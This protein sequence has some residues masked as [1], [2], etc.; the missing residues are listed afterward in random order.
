MRS[1]PRYRV[2]TGINRWRSCISKKGAN[3][4]PC[5]LALLSV[6]SLMA[7]IDILPLT[8]SFTLT[9]IRALLSDAAEVWSFSHP[10]PLFLWVI[11]P[12]FLCS[13][14]QASLYK[15]L[16]SLS[17]WPPLPTYPAF[18][19]SCCA[20]CLIAR[21][22][23]SLISLGTGGGHRGTAL[24]RFWRAGS[25][26]KPRGRTPWGMPCLLQHCPDMADNAGAKAPLFTVSLLSSLPP[27]SL[28]KSVQ[29]CTGDIYSS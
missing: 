24:R 13:E 10:P 18:Q 15:T 20:P 22:P 21:R 11:H 16:A 28:E 1:E 9:L 6:F 12:L 23:A 17:S 8:F 14:S 26:I 27:T 19:C 25:L 7:V 5:R 2:H 4:D 29:T 3:S